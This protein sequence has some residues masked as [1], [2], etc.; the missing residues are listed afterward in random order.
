VQQFRDYLAL[1]P[2]EKA[3]VV[4]QLAPNLDLRSIG[5]DEWRSRFLFVEGRAPATIR[6]ADPSRPAAMGRIFMQL[7]FADQ[8]GVK[9]YGGLRLLDLHFDMRGSAFLAPGVTGQAVTVAAIEGDFQGRVAGVAVERCRFVGDLKDPRVENVEAAEQLVACM[10][11][12]DDFRFQDNFA[13]RINTLLNYGGNDLVC[14][15]NYSRYLWEDAIQLTGIKDSLGNPIACGNW[16]VEENIDVLKWGN[17]RIHPDGAHISRRLGAP[18]GCVIDGAILR[19]NIFGVC[20]PYGFPSYPTGYSASHIV[21]ESCPATIPATPT[22]A[23]R[24]KGTGTAEVVE[25]ASVGDRRCVQVEAGSVATVTLVPAAGVSFQEQGSFA[26]L[27]SVVLTAPGETVEFEARAEDADTSVLTVSRS[28]PASQPIFANT[29]SSGP[30]EIRNI[31][32]EQNIAITASKGV[33]IRNAAGVCYLRNNTILPL[34]PGDANGDGN[35]NG[36]ADGVDTGRSRAHLVAEDLSFEI[37]GNIRGAGGTG[38]TATNEVE[39]LA[40][41][42]DFAAAFTATPSGDGFR[43]MPQTAVEIIAAAVPRGDGTLSA[44]TAGA[45]VVDGTDAAA[46]AW[47]AEVEGRWS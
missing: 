7:L 32:V 28:V 18:E 2:A 27:A 21:Y 5:R 26:P 16:L 34:F 36:Y 8:D 40:D 42:A 31:T 19:R 47:V 35:A 33:D 41:G 6:S 44:T 30:A 45:R 10:M 29:G 4:A 17:Y 25:A 39:L 37:S 12:A 38:L 11:L 15:R 1:D 22:Q 24:I 9:R 14:R 13:E 43:F 20:D 23:H 3:G 46:W